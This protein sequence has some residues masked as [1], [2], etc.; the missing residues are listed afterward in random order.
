[1]R[2]RVRMERC[3]R[4]SEL[5]MRHGWEGSG[6]GLSEE[7]CLPPPETTQAS[8]VSLQTGP[9]IALAEPLR[10]GAV[11]LITSCE[12]HWQGSGSILYM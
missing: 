3:C 8:G 10:F 7:A 1:M 5:E 6:G 9:K 12:L 2:V 11:R 4:I